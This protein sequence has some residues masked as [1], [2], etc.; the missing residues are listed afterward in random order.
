MSKRSYLFDEYVPNSLHYED[1]LTKQQG[2]ICIAINH[3]IDAVNR[4]YHLHWMLKVPLLAWL[5]KR[6][7]NHDLKFGKHLEEGYAKL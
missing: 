7:F 6:E 3:Q 4:Y 2:C 1:C 5:K